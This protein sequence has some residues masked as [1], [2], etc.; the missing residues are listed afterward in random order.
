MVHK[1]YS[2]FSTVR[3]FILVLDVNCLS[4]QERRKQLSTR[5]HLSQDKLVI[6]HTILFDWLI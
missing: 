3:N 1:V 6:H 2:I 4:Q 5:L